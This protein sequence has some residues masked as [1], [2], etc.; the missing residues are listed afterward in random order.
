VLRLAAEPLT[1][2]DATRR[3]HQHVE[4]DEVGHLVIDDTQRRLAVNRFDH[5]VALSLQEL[6]QERARPILVVH[7]EDQRPFASHGSRPSIVATNVAKSIGL[8]R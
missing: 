6:A 3:G 1:H 5:V 8:L 2:L 4:A 7:R